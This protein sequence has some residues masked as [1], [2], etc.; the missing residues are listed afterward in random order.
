MTSDEE[1]QGE[2]QPQFLGYGKPKTLK[3]VTQ[4]GERVAHDDDDDKGGGPPGPPGGG[5]EH[6]DDPAWGTENY[7]AVEL[8]NRIVGEWRYVAEWDDW[9]CWDGTRWAVDNT[10]A[11][12]L[13]GRRLAFDWARI[14]HT[15]G[16]ARQINKAQT[17]M[18]VTRL[19]RP[20]KR[21]ATKVAAIDAK[22]WLYNTPGGTVDLHTGQ[23]LPHNRDDLFMKIAGAAPAGNCP[24][25]RRF[26]DEVTGGDRDYRNYLQRLVGYSLTGTCEEEIFVFLYGP[27]NTGKSK[28]VETIRL[29]HGD[30]GASAPMDTFTKYIGERHPTDLA[31]FIGKRLVTAAETEEG[32]RWDQQRLTQLTGR[33]RISARFMRGDFFE[34]IPQFLLLFHGNFRPKLSEASDAM[35]RRMQL[36]PFMNKPAVIDRKLLDKFRAELGGIMVWAIEGAVLWRE[37]GLRPPKVVT[38]ATDLYFE[39]ENTMGEWLEERCV[40]GNPDDRELGRALYDDF[41]VWM[42][43]RGESYVPPDR[44]FRG[45]LEMI[46]GVKRAASHRNGRAFTGIRFRSDVTPHRRSPET[47]QARFLF[48]PGPPGA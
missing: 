16:W 29:L 18:A 24:H 2:A 26:L 14:V 45:R 41:F 37:H 7:L 43:L 3:V 23:C 39:L 6:S 1:P 47:R 36:L 21:I 30:Y 4:D 17:I 46:Q 34:Y 22:L 33:D 27:S 38:E 44:Q 31:G 25:W 19:A 11:Y 12:L 42:K 20:D 5:G 8:V 35:R 13:P 28:F 15:P 10:L 40:L 9:L 48:E 32:R